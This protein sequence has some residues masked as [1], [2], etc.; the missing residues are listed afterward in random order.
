MACSQEEEM[1]VPTVAVAPNL[2][3]ESSEII[4]SDTPLPFMTA[5]D[6]SLYEGSGKNSAA[7]AKTEATNAW[8]QFGPFTVNSTLTKVLTNH[9]VYISNADQPYYASGYY[10]CDVYRCIKTVTLQSGDVMLYEGSSKVG[11]ENY[12]AFDKTE[13]VVVSQTGNTY[14]FFT[15]SIVPRYTVTGQSLPF[16]VFP[17]DLTGTTFT[18]SYLRNI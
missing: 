15:W 6:L 7:N 4:T 8:T 9:K 2:N 3:V 1:V 13:G 16:R 14:D 11:Y 5:Y 17:R 10:L 12:S 18:Y